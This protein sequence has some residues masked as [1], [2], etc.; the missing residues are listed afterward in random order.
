MAFNGHALWWALEAMAHC[1]TVHFFTLP[2]FK[3]AYIQTQVSYAN[4]AGQSIMK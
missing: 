1:M 3:G 2:K 4:K